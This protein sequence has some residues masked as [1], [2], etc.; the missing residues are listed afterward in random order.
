MNI[1][2]YYCNV[3]RAS[4][5][6]LIRTC[7]WMTT[8]AGVLYRGRAFFGAGYSIIRKNTCRIVNPF[9]RWGDRPGTA[10]LRGIGWKIAKIAP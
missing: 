10:Y 9:G 8:R 4:W 6:E 7:S 3:G 5:P 1:D 2:I